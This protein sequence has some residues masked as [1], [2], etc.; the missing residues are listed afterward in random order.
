MN[1][2]QKATLSE[3]PNHP[4]YTE[5]QRRTTKPLSTFNQLTFNLQPS[6]N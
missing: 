6:T 3:Q 4:P 2:G 1:L 5:R